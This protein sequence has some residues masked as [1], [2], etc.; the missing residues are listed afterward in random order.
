MAKWLAKLRVGGRFADAA[1]RKLPELH[2]RI[3]IES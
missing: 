1:A 2:V 3:G